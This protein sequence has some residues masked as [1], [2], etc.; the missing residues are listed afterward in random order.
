MKKNQR[1]VLITGCSSGIGFLTALQFARNGYHVFATMRDIQSVGAKALL[2]AKEKEDLSLELIKM[3]ITDEN[4]VDTALEIIGKSFSHVDILINNAGF[5]Y[6]GPVEAYSL[7]EVKEQFETNVFGTLRL[8]KKI[9]PLMKDKKSGLIINIS[10]IHGFLSFPLW[11]IYAASKH[12]IEAFTEALRYEVAPIGIQV[13]LVEPGAFSTNFTGNRK[14]P[15]SLE[16]SEYRDFTLSFFKKFDE[17]GVQ[18]KKNNL[19]SSFIDP[20]RVALVIYSIADRA[21]LKFSY[22][23]GLDAHIYYFA[24]KILPN[25]VWDSLVKNFYRL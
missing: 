15:K 5:G 16:T 25:F 4:S 3:D 21:H 14:F 2:A 8:T 24:K 9:L 13:V 1:T 6:V 10:S 17:V 20:Q 23:V 12:A 19:L 7:E 11:G 22:R 18:V